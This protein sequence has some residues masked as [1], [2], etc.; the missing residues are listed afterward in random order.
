MFLVDAV[1][2]WSEL[3]Q[4]NPATAALEKRQ[5]TGEISKDL[6][7]MRNQIFSSMEGAKVWIYE[8][9]DLMQFIK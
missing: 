6:D 7:D 9:C 1:S 3:V 8:Y 4:E 2:K 5:R